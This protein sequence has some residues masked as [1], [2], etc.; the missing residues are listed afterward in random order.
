[1]SLDATPDSTPGAFIWLLFALFLWRLGDACDN[2][3]GWRRIM[4]IARKKVIVRSFGGAL[5]WGYLPQDGFVE[6]FNS[7]DEVDPERIGRRSFLGRPRGEG[8]WLKVEFRDGDLLEGLVHIDVQFMDVFMVDYGF[9]MVP[10]EA[11]SNTQ[12]LFIPRSAVTKVEVLG[13]VGAPGKKKA[14][15]TAERV[16]QPRLFEE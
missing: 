2:F 11:R 12:S 16:E 5:A 13:Y 6:D 9:R 4:A 7:E 14:K 10:P 15:A 1:M 3:G 8:L